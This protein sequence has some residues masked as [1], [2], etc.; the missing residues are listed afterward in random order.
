[1]E[2]YANINNNNREDK[3]YKLKETLSITVVALAFLLITGVAKADTYKNIKGTVTSV[4]AKYGTNNVHTPQEVCSVKEVPIYAQ[5]SQPNIVGAII[6]GYLGS[7]IGG[8]N[9][10]NIAIGTGAVIGSQMGNK[11]IVGYKQVRTCETHYSTTQASVLEYYII[12]WKADGFSGKAR[13][14]RSYNTGDSITVQLLA[15]PQL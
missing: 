14:N 11:K 12:S 5:D 8:G 4:E 1:M 13:S 15:Q 9:G 3:M 10:K 7:K 2:N 6:G